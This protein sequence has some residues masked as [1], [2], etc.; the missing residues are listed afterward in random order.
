MLT[1]VPMVLVTSVF[2]TLREVK[3]FGALTSYQSFFEKGSA[4]HSET[5]YNLQPSRQYGVL[6]CA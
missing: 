1:L 6:T 3:L 4:L 2:P 5:S